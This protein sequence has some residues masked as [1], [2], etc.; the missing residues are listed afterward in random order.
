[1]LKYLPLKCRYV[2]KLIINYNLKL[3]LYCEFFAIL[4]SRYFYKEVQILYRFLLAYRDLSYNKRS[5]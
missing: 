5:T 3:L 4:Y 2:L 1:M